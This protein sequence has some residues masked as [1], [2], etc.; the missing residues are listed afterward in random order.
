MCSSGA[1]YIDWEE[2]EKIQNEKNKTVYEV[3]PGE[4]VNVPIDDPKLWHLI[5]LHNSADELEDV[6]E[7]RILNEYPNDEMW[8]AVALS[9][10]SMWMTGF[11]IHRIVR[12]KKAGRPLIDSTPSHMWEEE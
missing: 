3:N 8:K 7:V 6:I 5:I 2:L 10:P 11:V 9:L 1:H 12:L 4:S